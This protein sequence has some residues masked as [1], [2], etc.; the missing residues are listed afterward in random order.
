MNKGKKIILLILSLIIIGLII[1]I[2]VVNNSSKLKIRLITE[3]EFIDNFN[4]LNKNNQDVYPMSE[5]I[6]KEEEKKD[7]YL[8]EDKYYLIIGKRDNYLEK[9]YLYTEKKNKYADYLLTMIKSFNSKLNDK[10]AKEIYDK[11]TDIKNKKADEVGLLV[12]FTKDG[13][14][15]IT[16][17]KG[18]GKDISFFIYAPNSDR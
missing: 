5:Y 1:G 9:V 18:N 8:F 15:Y 11:M 14:N 7:T 4:K 3:K 12:N 17:E 10:E 16:M 13:Y 6:H 2:V